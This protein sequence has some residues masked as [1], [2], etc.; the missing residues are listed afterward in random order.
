MTLAYSET[1]EGVPLVMLHGLGASRQ[2][3]T[4]L[5]GILKS[6]FRCISIDLPMMAESGPWAAQSPVDIAEKLHT[7]LHNKG[8]D[9]VTLIGHSY[10]GLSCL[11]YTARFPES[12]E[13]CFVISSPALGLPG[14]TRGLIDG[15][16][17]GLKYLASVTS[18][19]AA[20]RTLVKTYMQWNFGRAI[21][22]TDLHVDR[23][24]KAMSPPHAVQSLVEGAAAIGAYKIP[25]DALKHNHI[26]ITVIWGERDPVLAHIEGERLA[27]ALGA[28]LRVIHDV[29]HC[30]PEE[31]P[32]TVAEI[33][34]SAIL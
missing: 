24:L 3:F 7:F 32:E 20:S 12:V 30:V 8:L 11:E 28:P 25:I 1:G 34:A 15:V 19:L 21:P 4:E 23:Y 22:V 6:Q 16:M 27:R 13:Q 14:A 18:Q 33:I 2:I 9:H 26:P 29:G 10:G 31:A 5:I 17:P